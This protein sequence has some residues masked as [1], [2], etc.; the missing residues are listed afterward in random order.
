MSRPVL[1]PAEWH[2]MEYLW[3]NNPCTA[4]EAVEHL[5]S[6][7]GWSRSTTLTLLSR[8][9][10]KQQI[11]CHT[12][13]TVRTYSPMIAR[14]EAAQDQTRSFLDRVYQGS[15]SLM[16]SA[17]TQKQSLSDREIAELQAILDQAKSSRSKA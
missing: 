1:T 9:T 5:Q 8:M 7:V 13:G 6:K 15:L 11:R 17:F 10:E 2:V 4:R 16:V 12:E 3:Q 14:E